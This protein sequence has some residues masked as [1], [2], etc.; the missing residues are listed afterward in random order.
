VGH[1]P[2]VAVSIEGDDFWHLLCLCSRGGAYMPRP[3]TA[4]DADPVGGREPTGPR[5]SVAI[6]YQR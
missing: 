6:H 3:G 5:D 1:D 4:A 2:D